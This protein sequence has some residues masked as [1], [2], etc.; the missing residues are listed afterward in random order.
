LKLK[1]EIIYYIFLSSIAVFLL[2][3]IIYFGSSK[4]VIIDFN[5]RLFLGCLFIVCCLFGISLAIY[6]S[7][8]KRIF[9]VS[10]NRLGI[11]NNK[12]IFRK[13]KGHHPECEKFQ[14]HVISFNDKVVCTGCLGLA[15]GSISSIFLMLFYLIFINEKNV[16]IL[17]ALIFLGL[18]LIACN[19]IEIVLQFSNKIIHIF[20]NIFIIVGFFIIFIGIF[21]ITGS[22]TYAII[23]IIFSFLW[24][25][26][27]IQLSNIRHIIICSKCKEKCKMY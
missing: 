13:R 21:E 22:K 9:K 15:T 2:Q 27:R 19:Y 10:K 6:P 7:W 26:T 12:K 16:M 11:K 8:Y 5:D 14:N 3:I 25:Y 4:T 23:S 18:F 24:L 20:S 17:Y 1:N